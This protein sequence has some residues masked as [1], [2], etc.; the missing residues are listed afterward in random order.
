MEGTSIAAVQC[1][2][3]RSDGVANM[4]HRLFAGEV[5]GLLIRRLTRCRLAPSRSCLL[6][7]Y[8]V[9]RANSERGWAAGDRE[10]SAE[11]VANGKLRLYAGHQR[12]VER[13]AVR[14]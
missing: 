8:F 2:L 3:D 12:V 4:P 7:F 5:C 13:H 1:S 6:F 11:T 14:R 9:S 10:R